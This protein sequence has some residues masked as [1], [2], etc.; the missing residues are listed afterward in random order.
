MVDV[1]LE[2]KNTF[3]LGESLIDDM[4]EASTANKQI[5]KQKQHKKAHKKLLLTEEEADEYL[6]KSIFKI[7]SN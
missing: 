2:H 3:P 5:E 6:L 1:L 4:I 7:K